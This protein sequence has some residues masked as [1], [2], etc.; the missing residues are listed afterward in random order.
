MGSGWQFMA[1]ML[2]SFGTFFFLN[3][4]ARHIGIMNFGIFSVT[5]S[6]LT[7]MTM[8]ALTGTLGCDIWTVSIFGLAEVRDL[9]VVFVVVM[10]LWTMYGVDLKVHVHFDGV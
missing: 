10:G 1:I 8:F 9:L 3:W 2:T 5:E 4:R 7:G 6:Q